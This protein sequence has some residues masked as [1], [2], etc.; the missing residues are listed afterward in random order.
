MMVACG[1]SD[2][3]S[4][5]N[6]NTTLLANGEACAPA[7]NA[8]TA[9]ANPGTKVSR[10]GSNYTN[11]WWT[12]GDDP[13]THSGAAGSGQPWLK[14][15][16]CGGTATTTT[17][18]VGATT[19][20]TKTT[21]TTTSAPPPPGGFVFSAYKDVT[22]SADWNIDQMRTAVTGSTI[23][24]TQ[25]MSAKNKTLTWAFA[26]GE[27]GSENWAGM[28]P[29]QFAS[30][31]VPL[32][33]NAGKNYIVSTGGAAGSFTCGSDSGFTTFLNRYNSARMIGVDFD[34]EAGQSQA[35]IDSIITRVKNA[36]GSHP[37]LRFSFTIA[38]LAQN[39]GTS[40]ATDLGSGS[41]D[42]LGSTGTL[43]MN[44]IKALGLTNY[45]INL[46][47]MDYGTGSGVCVMSGGTCEMGQSANQAA[48][49]LHGHWGVP[50]NRIELTPMNG[51]NDVAAN[52]FSLANAGTMD[53]FV[54]SKGLAGVHY[55]SLDRD[56][57]LS[58]A[59]KF[60]ADL[61]L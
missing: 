34:I 31:N 6:G 53:A 50:Y 21:T 61:G 57:N 51:T 9:Y 52:V 18:K 22:V 40:T 41:P 42:S 32:F 33:V 39:N 49:N 58:F 47:V 2:T 8:T 30:T 59:N 54:K 4:A 23:P 19:T 43:I 10:S 3:Q 14:G 15:F 13:L 1:G 46:M 26:T 55:W 27:C 56:P 37:N 12:Q 24:V 48:L 16:T 7:W 35:V 28:A 20:T 11:N 29:A 25:A 5:A 36:Q 45:Y 17:T 38:T 44:R 60:I